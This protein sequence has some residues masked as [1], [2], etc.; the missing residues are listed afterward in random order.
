ML[1]L[2]RP[3]AQSK[4]P[5]P[6]WPRPPPRAIDRP[7]RTVKR[8]SHSSWPRPPS[9]RDRS[10]RSDRQE[11]L[12]FLMAETPAEKSGFLSRLFGRKEAPKETPKEA[13]KAGGH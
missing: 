10:T 9:P 3:P 4:S 5:H 11:E 12:A 13:P 8:S 1:R 6:S 7:G 2:S